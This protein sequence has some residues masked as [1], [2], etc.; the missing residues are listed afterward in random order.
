MSAMSAMPVGSLASAL[1][2]LGGSVCFGAGTVLQAIGAR[3]A[4]PAEAI[5]LGLLR[6]VLRS[7]PYLAGLGL[8]GLG[9]LLA[10]AAMR[11]LPVFAVE[12]L[13]ASYVAVVAALSTCLLG[14]RLR[15][16][17]WW[18]LAAMVLGLILLAFSSPAQ[19]HP[20]AALAARWALLTTVLVLAGF[21]VVVGRR[22]SAAA[23]PVAAFLG[24]VVWGVIPIAIRILPEPVL[25]GL[26]TDPAAYAIPVAG[27]LGLLLYT[28]ALQRT[29]V[30]TAT[31]MA[32]LGETLIPAAAGVLL[33][34][35][36]PRPTTA[37]LA[38]AGFLLSVTGALVLARYGELE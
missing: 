8:D 7:V 24:G 22:R 18:A 13:L 1:A 12:A 3:R 30:T 21:A 34:G 29:S 28:V 4:A 20:T 10:L 31:A 15:R 33:L 14:A 26:M 23:A 38:V 17:E 37:A 32:I 25:S 5:D 19:P 36:R 2:A 27:G 16:R 35:D 11:T 6:G 9:F